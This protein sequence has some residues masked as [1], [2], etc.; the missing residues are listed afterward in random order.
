MAGSWQDRGRR[1]MQRAR[2]DLSSVC[3][4][5]CLGKAWKALIS[6]WS[7]GVEYGESTLLRVWCFYNLE[8][9]SPYP[10]QCKTR[11]CLDRAALEKAGSW[12]RGHTPKAVLYWDGCGHGRCA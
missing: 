11:S 9:L 12:H 5:F 10:S 7:S 8:V 4:L 3:A 2:A 6:V 1:D